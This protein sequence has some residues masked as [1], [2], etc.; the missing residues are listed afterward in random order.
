M[1]GSAAIG[2]VDVDLVVL[3]VWLSEETTRYVAPRVSLDGDSGS[4]TIIEGV[5]DY[6]FDG[7]A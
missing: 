6:M 7:I 3:F 2:V 4:V 1:Y 5:V